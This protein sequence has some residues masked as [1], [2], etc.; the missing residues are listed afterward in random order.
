VY[1]RSTSLVLASFVVVRTGKPMPIVLGRETKLFFSLAVLPCSSSS[2]R[3]VAKYE[4][5]DQEARNNSPCD[6]RVLSSYCTCSL[7][8]IALAWSWKVVAASSHLKFV[9]KNSS[10]ASRTKTA[11]CYYCYIFIDFW[12]PVAI[13]DKGK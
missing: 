11:S 7:F 12:A 6:T 2:P 10:A 3:G 4:K 5:G 8:G 13:E 1:L 9:R